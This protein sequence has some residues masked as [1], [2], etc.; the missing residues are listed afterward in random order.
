[1]PA[2]MFLTG[3]I[4][5]QAARAL[6][7]KVVTQMSDVGF[8]ERARLLARLPQM[9]Q[10]LATPAFVEDIVQEMAGL[11]APVGLKGTF[12]GRRQTASSWAN[13]RIAPV[14]IFLAQAPSDRSLHIPGLAPALDLLDATYFEAKGRLDHTREGEPTSTAIHIA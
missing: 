10:Y 2:N 9:C 13:T 14:L 11:G 8:G 4:T 3:L 12:E 6:A 7:K 1:M 5:P